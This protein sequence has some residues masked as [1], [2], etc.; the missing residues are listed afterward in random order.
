LTKRAGGEP[1]GT[2]GALLLLARYGEQA[3]EDVGRDDQDDAITRQFFHEQIQETGIRSVRGRA[4][5][6]SSHLSVVPHD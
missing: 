1:S 4:T 5:L 3:T 2:A 6:D